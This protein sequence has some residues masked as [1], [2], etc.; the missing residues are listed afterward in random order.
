MTHVEAQALFARCR[1]KERGYRLSNNTRIQKRGASF[2]VKLYDTDIVIIHENG[3]YRLNSGGF[4]TVTTKQRMNDI[5]PCGAVYQKKWIWYFSD[6]FWGETL[7][8]DGMLIRHDGSVVDESRPTRK[9]KK[10]GE[11]VDGQMLFPSM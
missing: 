5:L 11:V 2:A 6:S 10:K 1:N 8:K 9:A 4:K 7:F 3:G